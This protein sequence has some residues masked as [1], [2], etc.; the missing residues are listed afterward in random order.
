MV[1]VSAAL[2]GYLVGFGDLGDSHLALVSR[3]FVGI[4][5]L[6]LAVPGGGMLELS[7][8]LLFVIGAVTLSIGVALSMLARKQ[9]LTSN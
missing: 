8:A 7:Q 5:G 4:A 1:L 9:I 3:L 2:Q 6:S